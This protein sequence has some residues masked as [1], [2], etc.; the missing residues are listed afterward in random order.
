MKIKTDRLIIREYTHADADEL[1]ALFSSP[2]TTPHSDWYLM[3][4]EAVSV[5][6]DNA[7]ARQSD[8]PRGYFSF[9]ITDKY[10]GEYWGHISL[11]CN[12]DITHGEIGRTI[13]VHLRN[14]GYATEALQAV[15]EFAFDSLRLTHILAVLHKD[16]I[17][18]IKS[19][20]KAGFSYYAPTEQADRLRYQLSNPNL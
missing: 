4:P 8:Q 9:A 7:V 16:N 17:S 2:E 20:E 3:T 13:K 6:L 14:K 1:L 15:I 10:S 18:S 5:F 19:L 11:R 12:E